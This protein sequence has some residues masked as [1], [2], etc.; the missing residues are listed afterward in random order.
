MDDEKALWVNKRLQTFPNGNDHQK[1]KMADEKVSKV[2]VHQRTNRN[3]LSKRRN[4]AL[5]GQNLKL[6]SAANSRWGFLG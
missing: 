2:T 3:C 4:Q 1:G 6:L 5:L